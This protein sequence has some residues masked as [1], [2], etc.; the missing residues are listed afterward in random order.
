MKRILLLLL[1]PLLTVLPLLAV[2]QFVV[3]GVTYKIYR[4]VGENAYCCVVDVDAS[5]D[6]II[7]KEHVIRP[8]NGKSCRVDSVQ[9]GVFDDH[10]NLRML[11]YSLWAGGTAN[12]NDVKLIHPSPGFK[13]CEN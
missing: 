4:N 10:H 1:F 12:E 7:I 13:G 3:D 6:T 11:Y 8:N 5:L 9:L 2:E